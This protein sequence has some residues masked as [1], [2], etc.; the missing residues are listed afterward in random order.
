[1]DDL[2]EM[3]KLEYYTPCSYIIR[4]IILIIITLFPE[5]EAKR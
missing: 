4:K 3:L 2:S 1:M 5:L